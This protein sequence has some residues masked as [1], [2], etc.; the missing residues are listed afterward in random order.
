MY[1]YYSGT[2]EERDAWQTA[3]NFSSRPD[4]FATFLNVEEEGNNLLIDIRLNP[5]QPKNGKQFCINVNVRNI[6][7]VDTS[8]TF[9]Y[10]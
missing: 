4:Y 6:S 5:E 1:I 3:F 8:G 10:L 9:S 2:E 7:N